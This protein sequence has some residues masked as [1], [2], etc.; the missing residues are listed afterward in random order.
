MNAILN[1]PR[2]FASGLGRYVRRSE[3]GITMTIF[4]LALVV[5]LGFVAVGVDASRI[6]DERRRA[7]N[8]ADNAAIAASFAS[9]GG[10]SLAASQTAGRNSANANGY[11]NNGTTN[12]V[13]ITLAPG[14]V[15]TDHKFVATIDTTIGTTFGAL[16][17]LGTL[18]TETD[19]TA[20]ATGCGGGGAAATPAAVHAGG[21]SCPGGSLRTVQWN[22][23][24][25]IVNGQTISYGGVNISGGTNQFRATAPDPSILYAGS[26]TNSG[27]GNTFVPARQ[28]TTVPSPATNGL[29]AGWRVADLT[30]AMWNAYRDSPDRRNTSTT[31]DKFI[32]NQNGI[33][34]TDRPGGVTVEFHSSSVNSVTFV[35]RTGPIYIGEDLTSRTFT[36]YPTPTGGK[37]N[38]I[39]ISGYDGGGQPCDQDA[40]RRSGQGGT[41]NGIIWAPR[42][43]V[44]WS[45]NLNTMNGSV[46]AHAVHNRGGNQQVFNYNAALFPASALPDVILIH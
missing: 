15:A 28:S 23:N 40:I 12:T 16:L 24:T 10:A 30:T 39:M 6:Y 33:Y 43:L 37:P 11:N 3:D 38:A 31:T 29:P 1:R 22:G 44:N 17:G 21:T 19:A 41:W 18:S 7:Q 42:A 26:W 4:A 27:T 36:A 14:S 20:Q 25:N 13:T 45:G 8:A 32:V 5:L 46:I 35:N 9:C 34:Y 2:A